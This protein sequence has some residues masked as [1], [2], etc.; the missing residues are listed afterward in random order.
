[1]HEERDMILN[2]AL[3][4]LA[5]FDE[6][7]RLNEEDDAWREISAGLVVLRLVDRW[8][9]EGTSVVA[10]DAWG[11]T[12][13]V[14]AVDA[15]PVGR[16]VRGMLRSVVDA[17]GATTTPNFRTV[18]PRLMAYARALDFDARWQLAVDVYH[19]VIAFSE[20]LENADTVIAAHLRLGYC[21]RQIGEVDQSAAAYAMAGRI[22]EQ[23]GDM[24]GVLRARI[25]DAKIAMLRG[26]LPRAEVILDETIEDAGKHGL[27]GVESMALQDR[28]GVAGLRG[29]YELAVR[30]AYRALPGTESER[31]RDRLLHD[32][33]V[34]FGRLGVRSAARDA[35]LVLVAT[36]ADQYVRWSSSIQ[37]LAISAADGVGPM[38]EKYRQ[39]LSGQALPSALRA[40]FEYETGRG[41]LALGHYEDATTWLTAAVA[42]ANANGL[43]QTVFEAESELVQA[44]QARRLEEQSA[45]FRE[46][47]PDLNEV[48]EAIR[49][50][51]ETTKVGGRSG[52]LD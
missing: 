39:E 20:P 34:S 49:M 1:M 46:I 17:M 3:R 22:A 14:D 16:P 35:F 38:F 18:A 37:L 43:Y 50:L 12:S 4:H 8:L 29:N 42:T 40:E 47:A 26:N 30:L 5:F 48:A 45:P 44:K 52:G 2:A 25:G 6:L 24:V 31:N 11:Y 41:Y 27:A 23:T 15:I 9:E 10:A 32:I 33:A 51:R 19:T 21:L 7:S 28:A 13:V 36:S